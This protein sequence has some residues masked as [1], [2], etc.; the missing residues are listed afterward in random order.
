MFDEEGRCAIIR[1]PVAYESQAKDMRLPCAF[2]FLAAGLYASEVMASVACRDRFLE[3]F[4][5]TS[6]WNTAIGSDATFAAANLYPTGR[7]PTQI[8]N[9][10][11]FFLRV[12]SDTDIYPLTDWIDQGDWGSDDHCKITGKVGVVG[13]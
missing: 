13:E 1:A 3:P 7:Y 8:H 11:D 5:S 9:D 12:T 6:I 10:Q 4:S 2:L